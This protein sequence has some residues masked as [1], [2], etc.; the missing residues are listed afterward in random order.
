MLEKR[1]GLDID[2][3]KIAERTNLN[4]MYVAIGRAGLTTRGSETSKVLLAYQG[5]RS[6]VHGFDV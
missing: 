2:K 3:N 4:L 1:V 6:R 5:L